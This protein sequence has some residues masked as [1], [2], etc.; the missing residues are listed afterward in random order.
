MSILSK[1]QL[2]NK[3]DSTVFLNTSGQIKADLHNTLLKDFVD[4]FFNQISQA[5]LVGLHEHDTN[6][7]YSQ[8]DAVLKYNSIWKANKDTSGNFTEADWDLVLGL[9][10]RR[11]T[12]D[13]VIDTKGDRYIISDVSGGSNSITLPP[14][15]GWETDRIITIINRTDNSGYTTEIL[16]DGTDKINGQ[17]SL[18]LD[19]EFGRIDLQYDS[20][21][22]SWYA[23]SVW[24]VSQ[25]LTRLTDQDFT[26]ALVNLNGKSISTQEWDYLAQ[27]DQYVR[28]TDDV[29]HLYSRV[30][31][32]EDTWE[33][34]EMTSDLHDFNSGDNHFLRLD[35]TGNYSLTGVEGEDDGMVLVVMNRTS[36]KLTILH[37]NGNSDSGNQFW[38]SSG[39][40]KLE[41]LENGIAHFRYERTIEKWILSSRNEETTIV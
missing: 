9:R 38:I 10:I 15:G 23:L 33:T 34:Y 16:P 27:Q 31:T 29:R 36:N 13:H 40:G 25:E 35:P 11:I 41:L 37:L 21:D 17:N 32:R 19:K 22:G 4:S 24:D 1:T 14:T 26:N 5:A 3:I 7:S 6:A 20:G 18:G 8:G 12:S 30:N 2:K 39:G 28:T